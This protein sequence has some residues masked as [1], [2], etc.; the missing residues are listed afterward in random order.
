[1]VENEI[2][3]LFGSRGKTR[4]KENDVENNPSGPT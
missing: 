2:F 1:M 4:E 3:L